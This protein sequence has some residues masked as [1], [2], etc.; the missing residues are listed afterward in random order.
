MASFSN[1]RGE[2]AKCLPLPTCSLW[3]RLWVPYRGLYSKVSYCLVESFDLTYNT[4][5]VKGT[6]PMT[7]R[8]EVVDILP[9]CAILTL[10]FTKKDPLR[11]LDFFEWARTFTRGTHRAFSAKISCNSGGEQL[12]PLVLGLSKLGQMA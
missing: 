8:S 10:C 2:L 12:S 11:R 1:F 3:P 9:L 5:Q 7:Q 4:S 6:W